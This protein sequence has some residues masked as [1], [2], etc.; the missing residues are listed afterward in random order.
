MRLSIWLASE[1]LKNF[2]FFLDPPTLTHPR[3]SQAWSLCCTRLG[4]AWFHVAARCQNQEVIGTILFAHSFSRFDNLNA[5][6]YQS[7][8]QVLGYQ[9][10]I[11]NLT[12]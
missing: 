12:R 11:L 8:C 7:I 9:V 2:T 6:E 5:W 10:V 3:D 4:L 1:H